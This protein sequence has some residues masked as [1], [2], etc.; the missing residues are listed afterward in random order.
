MPLGLGSDGRIL[1]LGG[2]MQM[3]SRRISKWKPGT[4]ALCLC[5][6]LCLSASMACGD[7]FA[8]RSQAVTDSALAP[9]DHAVVALM[10]DGSVACTGTLVSPLVVVTAR[11]CIPDPAGQVRIAF[12]PDPLIAELR[13]ARVHWLPASIRHDVGL[14]LL[15]TA[16]PGWATPAALRASPMGPA[17]VDGQLRIVGFGTVNE[18]DETP[19]LRRTGFG[20]ITTVREFTFDYVGDPSQACL[21]DSGGPNFMANGDGIEEL[22]GI[23]SS[24]DQACVAGGT[25]AR[26]DGL[27]Q[28]FILPFIAASTPGS[29]A[30]GEL[31]FGDD[32]CAVG[33]CYF[34]NDAPTRG[35]CSTS[36]TDV[37]ECASTL[38]CEDG[39]CLYPLPSPGAIGASCADDVACESRL[40]RSAADAA[41]ELR[42]TSYCA[43]GIESCP[44]GNTCRDIAGQQGVYGCFPPA[45]AAEGCSVAP[46]GLE[47]GA[48]GV[49]CLLA[50]L[51][52]A[53][54]R[55]RRRVY[56]R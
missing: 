18:T 34:P 8:S 56:L 5:A 43:A 15:D 30:A 16:A 41:G 24:G 42:C 3:F 13:E 17:D 54:T 26:I 9:D 55:R 19:A 45:P 14:I 25:D 28:S 48:K 32:T 46:G 37:G 51:F 40:C 7:Q 12:G 23:T 53:V 38:R 2:L 31:C 35:Y 50:V 10:R 20:R 27:V 39:Q 29:A 6:A 22:V 33:T 44:E 1:I 21:G 4:L 49:L 11:H 36:C 52:F 47:R